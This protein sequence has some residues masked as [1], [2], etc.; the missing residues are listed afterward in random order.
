VPAKGPRPTEINK[1][2]AH[3]NSGMDL[4]AFSN[5]LA[6]VLKIAVSLELV[7]LAGRASMMPSA[8]ASNVPTADIAIVSNDAIRIFDKNVGLI[9]GDKSS[10]KNLAINS[11]LLKEKSLDS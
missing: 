1:S 5:H 9:L 7:L 10:L 3:T 4:R 6:G 11:R 8:A 2:A